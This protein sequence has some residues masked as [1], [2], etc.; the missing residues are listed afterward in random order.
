MQSVNNDGVCLGQQTLWSPGVAVLSVSDYLR[1][2]GVS[3]PDPSKVRCL[4]INSDSTIVS[5]TY[6]GSPMR[7]TMLP[8]LLPS[9]ATAH[10]TVATG[11]Q[12]SVAAPGLLTSVS[13][14]SPAQ[15][16]VDVAPKHS[17]SFSWKPDGSFQYVPAPGF[18]GRDA[19]VFRATNI[20]GASNQAAAEITVN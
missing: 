6:N 9:A 1:E 7:I 19:F 15:I 8:P 11:G 10:F 14:R 12:L 16:I 13:S 3:I 18:S 4:R 2:Q 5:G 17:S 20:V